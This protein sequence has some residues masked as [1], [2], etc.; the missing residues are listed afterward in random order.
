MHD[1]ALVSVLDREAHLAKQLQAALERR[2][3]DAV[4]GQRHAVDV[5][6]DQ[7]RLASLRGAAVEQRNDAGVL[8]RGE[9]LALGAEAAGGFAIGHGRARD[10]HRH[11]LG[12]CAVGAVG[13]VDLPHAAFPDLLSQP[14]RSDARAGAQAGAPA[15]GGAVAVRGVVGRMAGRA[16]E[17]GH[18]LVGH[19][20]RLHVGAQI[21]SG[22]AAGVERRRASLQRQLDDLVEHRLDREEVCRCQPPSG[23]GAIAHSV[24][25]RCSQA[26]ANVQC[27]FTVAGAM[28]SSSAVSWIERP[29]K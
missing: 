12:E 28:S 5:L 15:R 27:R 16:Q 18:A 23:V 24:S 17:A 25:A 21:G 22:G 2:G 8:E 6:H 26:R 10:L 4:A 20:Q 13:E 3:A 1:A 7:V 11:A 29:V 14:V 19:E 9:N